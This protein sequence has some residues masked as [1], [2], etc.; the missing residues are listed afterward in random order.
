MLIE[1]FTSQDAAGK[2]QDAAATNY[3]AAKNRVSDVANAAAGKA[4]DAKGEAKVG[5]RSLPYE[6]CLGPLLVVMIY[7]CNWRHPSVMIMRM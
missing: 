6:Q 2:V 7:T 3:D 1:R 5:K 4:Q